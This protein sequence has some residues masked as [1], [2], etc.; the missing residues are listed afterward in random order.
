MSNIKFRPVQGS[1]STLRAMGYNEGYVYF[2]TDTKKIY[3]D[4]EGKEKVPMGGNSGIYYG[5]MT[6][7]E[8]PEA[9]QKQFT[10]TAFDIDGNI[11]LDNLNIPNVNDL[12]LNVPDGCFYRVQSIDGEGADVIITTE[13]LTIAG[14]S[15]GPSGPS[16]PTGTMEMN[17]LTTKNVT[18]L[19]GSPYSIGF[20]LK[21]TNAAGEETGNGSYELFIN[22]VSKEKGTAQ[23]GNNYLEISQ[24]LDLRKNTVRVV[25]YMDIGGNADVPMSLTWEITATEM[26]LEWEQ[27][28]TAIHSTENPFTIEW[29]V[30]G[31]GIDKT[32]HIIIDDLYTVTTDPT[33]TSD[34]QRKTINPKEYNLT[35]GAHKFQIYATASLDGNDVQT[36][37]MF[38]NFIFEEPGNTNPILSLG[39]FETNLT[40]YN[41][42]SIPVILYSADNILSN[43]TVILKEDGIIKDTWEAVPNSTIKYW[44]YTPTTPNDHI[45]SVHCGMAETSKIINVVALDIDNEEIGDYA[46]KFRANDF[47]SNNAVQNWSNNGVTATFSPKF[48]WVNGGL[49]TEL[50]DS[51]NARQLVCI[52][53]GSTMT[54]NYPLFAKNARAAGKTFKI[55]FKA[56]NCRDYDA[57]VLSCKND[58]KIIQVYDDLETLLQ[59]DDNTEVQYSANVEIDPVTFELRL[60]DPQTTTF[61]LNDENSRKLLDNAYVIIE[62]TIYECHFRKVEKENEDD[63]QLYYAAWYPMAVEDSFEGIMMRAQYA[64]LNS[65]SST[66]TTQYCEDTYIELEFDITKY[67]SNKIR[68]YI[69][70]W[71]DGIP[72]GFVVYNAD[73]I[74]IDDNKNNIV[75]GSTDCDVYVYMVKLYEYGL[76]NDNHLENF[77]ADAPNAEEM[78]K[79]YRRNDILHDE[80]KTEIDPAKLAAAN[81]DCLV[82][83]YEIPRMT[84]TKKDK[85]YGCTYDQYHGSDKI[86]LHAEGVVI[87][88]QGTSSEKYVVSAANIDSDFWYTD[89]D[90]PYTPTGFIDIANNKELKEVGWSMDGGNAIPCNFFCTKVNVAS[91][92][93]AN[94]AL[95]QEWYNMFQPYQSVV[96]CKNKNARDTMQFTNGVMF[97]KDLNETFS[98]DANH[99]KK[100]NNVFGEI[101]GYI[102]KGNMASSA[103]PKLYSLANM[104][105]S[106]DNTH[107]FHDTTNPK[108][109]CIEVN[110][111]QTPQQWMTSDIY[112]D[113][114]IDDNK[115]YYGFRYP[116]GVEN[117]TPEMINGWRE[118]VSWMAHSNPQPKYLEHTEIDTEKKFKAFAFNQKTQKSI[119]VYVL[120]EEKTAYTLVEAFDPNINI[121]YTETDNIYGYTNLVLPDNVQKTYGDYT[122]Q[123]FI[124]TEQVDSKGEPWQKNYKPMI[125]GCKVTEY[126]GTYTHDTYEYRMAKMLHECEEHLIMDSVVY[127]YLFVE[128][129]TMI[130]NIAK[131]TFW[132]TEDCKHWNLVKD[133]DNDTSNGNDNNGKFTRNY[134]M[135]PLDKLNANTYVFN[136]HQSVWL[137]FVHGLSEACEH[138]YQALE[139]KKVIYNGR[140]LSAWSATDY[141]WLFNEWQSRIPERCW[142]EDYYR[143][144]F[145]PYELYNDSMFISMME[146][147]Q[148]KY[149][150]KQYET[151]QET[152]VSSEYNGTD[153]RSSYMLVRSNGKNMLGYQLPV[154]VYSD[155]YIRMDTGSDTSVARVKR[156]QK[157]Y[158]ECPTDSLNNATMYFYP[159]KAFSVIGDIDG[160]KLGEMLPEQVSFAQAGKLRELIVATQDSTVNETLE[161]GFSVANNNLLEKLYVANLS[162]YTE[163]LDLSKC[164][165]LREVDATGSSFTSI[166]IADNAPVTTI[167]LE[168]PTS[169][170]L[171]NLTELETLDINR[172]NRLSILK[173]NNIDKSEINSKDIVEA[174]INASALQNYKL[175]EVDWVITNPSEIN[176]NNTIVILEDLLDLK[177]ITN[178]ESASGY[179]PL[180][181]SLTGN[182][183]IKSNAY[184]G[185]ESF[186][187]YNTYAKPDVYPDFVIDFENKNSKLYT[188]DILDGNDAVYWTRKIQSGNTIDSIFLSDGPNG[189]FDVEKIIKGN[190]PAF[191]YTFTGQWEVY[192]TEGMEFIEL[193]DERDD[194]MP[195]YYGPNYSGITYDITMRPKF[196]AIDREYE[197]KFFGTD[198]LN[199]FYTTTQKYGTP[200]TEVLPTEIPYKEYNGDNL[201]SDYNFVGY[202]LIQGSVNTVPDSYTVQ[203]AQS[204]YAVF[205]FVTDISTIVHP[206]WFEYVL[207]PYTW[208]KSYSENNIIPKEDE[209]LQYLDGTS[210]YMVYPKVSLRGKVTIPASYNGKP[211]VALGD[212][213]KLV[214]QNISHIFFEKG[215]KVYEIKSSAFANMT[216]LRHIDF[217]QN[218]VRYIGAQAFQGCENIDAS[219]QADGTSKFTLS[220]KL[221]CIRT[222]AFQN[223]LRSNTV[224]EIVIPSSVVEIGRTG[225]AYNYIQEGST[226]RIGNESMLSTLDL[227]RDVFSTS[228]VQKFVQNDGYHYG[229]IYFF[230]ERYSS[231]DSIISSA[232]E[233]IFVRDAF[234]GDQE[235]GAAAYPNTTLT[236]TNKKGGIA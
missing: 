149:Q 158:F 76:S 199:P 34:Y 137:N 231:A 19:Y 88:V 3:L 234:F 155:C 179:E 166:E 6:L 188:V 31:S 69:K 127:H 62:N 13:R 111:N 220:N 232:N 221:F 64:T 80:R 135:E 148:K 187:I 9:G 210:S 36:D 95:N 174:A 191:T 192:K 23:Q 102:Q 65:R 171:S 89:S 50:D 27:S 104:G 82:H 180:A 165:N 206:E 147:G 145:R 189:S 129:H 209:Y 154:E 17:R 193:L 73:D 197:L 26:K 30:S 181:A 130:D 106:K 132:S 55:I 208:D 54:I 151:Y 162:K 20:Q 227:V 222:G 196:I 47:A 146:G 215:S 16:T 33:K 105:N 49:K 92:E 125:R 110:D 94:N 126:S 38:K 29:K 144:Y 5:K 101:S 167:K 176:S 7:P 236:V 117:A 84:K 53:A 51:G 175:T 139:N 177:P 45:L 172:Y 8:V 81:K 87:K 223:A 52:K 212:F 140:E 57:Q 185:P 122:F 183:L 216:S 136:A 233:N 138:M 12:I 11:D 35:H 153:H 114:D 66:I 113:S 1:E 10:F 41:T 90:N 200:F 25:A 128:R 68:N 61:N 44:A 18:V 173:L 163:G 213:S 43:A 217:S 22:G 86:A 70:F 14:S 224:T 85:V 120:N 60:R 4:T 107:V 99:D 58:K 160:G 118:F 230:S 226:L 56:T 74:F 156:N 39:L 225:F 195:Y 100:L 207:T 98:T 134:G 161:K 32:T 194:K 116:D 214:P 37:S 133:Y 78:I 201:K 198:L 182:L 218:T 67:D 91:C 157:A 108:E 103:Y 97:I 235:D 40:Q 131:N 63:P 184:N 48:D 96:R 168:N 152:Y 75:I 164:P 24:Y 28:Q 186:E 228:G 77:I 119:P 112:L 204:F 15:N 42:V 79:R 169:L 71:I 142:I 21:A 229:N 219:L 205:E 211:V 121:Y 109:C 83:V 124:A 141:L 2:A 123:G 190:T 59:I 203:N 150:R 46:F 143:K 72:S 170:N 93:N 202:S 115:K 159:A 178:D